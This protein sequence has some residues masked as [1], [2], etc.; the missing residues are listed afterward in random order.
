MRV[1]A[2]ISVLAHSSDESVTWQNPEMGVA[3][4]SWEDAK[5]IR[6]AIRWADDAGMG[7]QDKEQEIFE[8]KFTPSNTL[9][10]APKTKG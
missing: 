4:F 10:P 3:D 2:D 5:M 6:R 7:K 8:S 1:P 9:G